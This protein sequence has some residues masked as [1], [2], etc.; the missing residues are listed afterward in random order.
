M[1]YDPRTLGFL[2]LSMLLAASRIADAASVSYV[3]TDY[4]DPAHPREVASGTKTYSA[5]DIRVVPCGAGDEQFFKKS[6]KLAAGYWI[7]ASINREKNI[8]GFGLWATHGPRSFSWE[9]FD[10]PDGDVFQKLQEGGSVRVTWRV[11]EGLEELASITFESDVS[12]RV[13]ETFEVGKVS[14]RILIR[15]GSVLEFPP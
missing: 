2:A 5:S 13:D 11:V 14:H 8:D 12:L 3:I 7:G 1:N 6:L 10:R 15:K 9:W 4:V